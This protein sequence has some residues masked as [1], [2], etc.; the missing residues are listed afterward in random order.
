MLNGFVRYVENRLYVANAITLAKEHHRKRNM[1][2]GVTTLRHHLA[3]NIQHTQATK[4]MAHMHRKMS[5]QVCM[6]RYTK[7]GTK[8]DGSSPLTT[9]LGQLRMHAEVL[10]GD[11]LEVHQYT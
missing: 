5:L 10:S 9:T 1:Q 7:V 3:A 8:V 6:D 4:I 11:T 2:Q